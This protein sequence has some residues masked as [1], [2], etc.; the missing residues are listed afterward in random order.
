MP[1]VGEAMAAAGVAFADL[2]RLAVTVGPGTFS[3]V[4]TGLAAARGLSLASGVPLVGA[5]SLAVMALEAVALLG[6]RLSGRRL[7]VAI[8]AHKSQLY[9]QVF[10]A[11]GT[12]RGAPILLDRGAAAA[13]AGGQDT[14]AVGNGAAVLADWLR[15][16]GSAITCALHELMPSA[17]RLAIVA[18][19]L[20]AGQQ[21]RPLYLRA[22]DAVPPADA[23]LARV[24]R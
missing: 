6:D 17:R 21:V 2:E 15:G 8:D 22:P 5:T 11:D 24:E 16:S 9:V 19:R 18:P 10:G 1:L 3:G 12:P 13:F 4:R 23:A 20:E 7:A 14:I